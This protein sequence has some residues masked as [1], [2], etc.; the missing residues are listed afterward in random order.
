MGGGLGDWV[1][2][3]KRLRCTD[4]Q[5][6]NSHGDVQYSTGDIVTNIVINMC[7]ARWALDLSRVDFIG[8]INV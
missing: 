1:K 4:W 2:R 3:V 7:G 5:L 8:Y 6:Q